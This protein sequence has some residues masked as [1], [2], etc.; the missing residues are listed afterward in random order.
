MNL[1]DLI[2]IQAET[3]TKDS[4][5][6]LSRKM[7]PLLQTHY[8]NVQK[9]V[10]AIKDDG[11]IIQMSNQSQQIG[12]EDQ[13]TKGYQTVIYHGMTRNAE[14]KTFIQTLPDGSMKKWT[15]SVS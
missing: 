6:V 4:Q 14:K 8:N 7:N 12:R 2:T 3:M 15:E 13:K 1:V 10:K 5:T 9:V 11:D